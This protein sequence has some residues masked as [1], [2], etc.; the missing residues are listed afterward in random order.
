MSSMT[1]ER[2]EDYVKTM[3]GAA[4][5]VHLFITQLL[6]GLIMQRP[7]LVSQVQWPLAGL[8]LLWGWMVVRRSPA[9]QYVRCPT[10]HS[11]VDEKTIDM[12]SKE[13]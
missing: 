8:A 11:R 4:I 9:T 1:F 10:C 5:C 6:F 12:P 2:F 7:D 3:G 13:P